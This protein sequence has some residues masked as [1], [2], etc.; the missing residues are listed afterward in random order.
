V[1]NLTVG[2]PL[3]VLPSQRR[4]KSACQYLCELLVALPRAK[5]A[6]DYEARLPWRLMPTRA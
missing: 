2:S 6:D 3:A 1:D 4:P 5:T